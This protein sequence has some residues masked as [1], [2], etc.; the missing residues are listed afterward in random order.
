MDCGAFQY[1]AVFEPVS[2]DCVSARAL[3]SKDV[4]EERY[5]DMCRHNL[6]NVRQVR[7]SPEFSFLELLKL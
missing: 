4:E 1:D 5:P 7:I 2:C 3:S 6:Q